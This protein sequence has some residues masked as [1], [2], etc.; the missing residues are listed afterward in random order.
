MNSEFDPFADTS[1]NSAR[2]VF[3]YLLKLKDKE[4]ISEEVFVNKNSERYT[5]EDATLTAYNIYESLTDN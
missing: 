1:V 4:D 5:F 3:D 2:A